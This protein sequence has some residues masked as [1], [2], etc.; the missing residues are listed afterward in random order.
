MSDS[1]HHAM[2]ELVKLTRSTDLVSS[3][4]YCSQLSTRRGACVR[5]GESLLTANKCDSVILAGS[6]TRVDNWLSAMSRVLI[7]KRGFKE[8][9]L[10][11]F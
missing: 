2:S 5:I 7:E 9:H 1:K 4:R 3:S 11:T 10:C 8:S 6:F